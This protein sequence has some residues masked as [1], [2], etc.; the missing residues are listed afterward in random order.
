MKKTETRDSNENILRSRAV[1]YALLLAGEV[2]AVVEAKEEEKDAYAALTQE[3]RYAEDIST[4]RNYGRFGVPFVFTANLEEAWFQDVRP[5]APRER[6]LRNFHRPDGLDMFL[7]T[8]YEGAK[9][10]LEDT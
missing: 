2:T 7:N 8:D 5:E 3:K 4:G 10:W 1:D 9:Q 6:K